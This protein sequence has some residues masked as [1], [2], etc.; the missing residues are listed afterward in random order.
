MVKDPVCGM[1]IEESKAYARREYGGR[2]FFFCSA[3]C[4]A[5][6]AA[7]PA[8]YAGAEQGGHGRHTPSATTGVREGVAGPKRVELPV[9]DLTCARCVQAVEKAAAGSPRREAGHSEPRRRP[10]LR[11]L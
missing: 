6:F 5:T 2:T 4:E 10:G 9:F 11:G 7:D 1:E 3:K 8:R